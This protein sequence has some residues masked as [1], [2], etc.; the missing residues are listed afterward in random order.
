[1]RAAIFAL[2]TLA[3]MG[4]ATAQDAPQAKASAQ[5]LVDAMHA[6]FGEH[7][8]RAVHTNGIMLEG[9]FSP[10]AD[11]R[12]LTKAP[13]F[14]G[15][16]LPVIARF[17][18]FA[19][20]PNL[21][22]NDDGA[23]PAGFG[24]KIRGQDGDD[25]DIETNQ[26]KDF[27]TAT[28]EEFRTFL[29]AVAAADKGD[30]AP[31]DAFLA[32]HPHAREFL[33]TRSYPASYAKAK[34]FGV[35]AVKFTNKTGKASFVRYQVVPRAGE[36]YLSAE[37]RKAKGEHYLQDE[38]VRRV[39]AGPVVF[40]WYA[41]VAE[42]GDKIEDPSIAWPDTRRRVKLGTFTL[43]RQPS[44]P[45]GAQRSLLLLPGQEH[46]GVAPADPMLV[47]RNEAYPISFGQRQ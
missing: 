20:V 14:A 19:G 17:S 4:A 40:D 1:V 41:Q 6:A 38:L 10:T 30:K 3:F 8:A 32:S 45:D 7:H 25:F 35:N 2:G 36:A 11:A 23:A 18:T 43:K 5:D 22:D 15:K 47:L 46:P 24:V 28:S 13:T 29:L 27:I 21:P 37:Q 42:A 34:Y 33:A 12:K 9:T 31:L 26:H 44:D 39:A 16:T